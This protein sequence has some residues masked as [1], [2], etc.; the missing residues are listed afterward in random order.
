MERRWWTLVAVLMGTFMLLLDVTV[1]NVALPKIQQDLHS[2]LSDLQWVVDAYSL[3]LAALLLLA[4]SLADRYGRRLIFMAGLALFSIASLTC[5]LAPNATFLNLARGVQGVGGAGMLATGLALIAQEFQ[6]RE[7]GTAIAAFGATIGGAVAI[8]PL[9]GGVLTDGLGWQWIFFVNVPIGALALGVAAM[10]I[11]ESR[12]PHAGPIDL[13]G[14]V[15]FSVSLFLVV[16]ALLRG[17]A[18]GWGSATIVGS[19]I[20]SAVLMIAFVAVERRHAH[21]MFDLGLFRNPTFVGVSFATVALGAGMLATYLYLT[22]YV[23]DVLGISPLQA[24]LRFLPNTLPAFIVPAVTRNLAVRAPARLLLG[25]GMTLV[26]VGLLLM[27]GLTVTSTWTAL[28]AG[29]IVAGGG[30]GLSNPTIAAA[31]IGVVPVQRSGMASGINNTCRLAGVAAGVGALGAVFA[32]QVSSHLDRLLGGH[33]PPGLANLATASGSKGVLAVTHNQH[34]AAAARAAFVAS[35][36]E[37]LIIG[38]IIVF[39]GALAAFVLVRARDFRT[40]PAAAAVP[41]PVAV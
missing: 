20:G 5:G 2:S 22:L 32:G 33:A 38:A 8:G 37:L 41:E 7:R 23:Q 34:L 4:G 24:G 25:S 6:G 30:I 28:L 1:V 12:N 18:D 3:M 26:G 40:E 31:A 13:G 14:F 17:N 35:L 15:T 29:F 19:L 39:A 9:V 16:F 10:R 11:R 36:N 21:P 27:H